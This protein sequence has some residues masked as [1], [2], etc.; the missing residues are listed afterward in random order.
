MWYLIREMGAVH[1]IYRG[2]YAKSNK[3]KIFFP[4]KEKIWIGA[5]ET[6]AIGGG[7]QFLLTLDHIIADKKAYM[8][9]PARKEGIIPGA[10]N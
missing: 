10:A 8:T 4:S 1:K 6:F 2:I 5:L 3:F 7:C 9:L